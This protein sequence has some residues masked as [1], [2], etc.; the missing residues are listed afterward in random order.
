MIK[1]MQNLPTAKYF[2]K[3]VQVH[4]QVAGKAKFSI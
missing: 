2:G 4:K 3:D 1:T